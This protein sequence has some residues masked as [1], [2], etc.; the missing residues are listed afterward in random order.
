M[1]YNSDTAGEQ[2]NSKSLQ[3]CILKCEDNSGNTKSIITEGTE[4]PPQA[5]RS[6][7]ILESPFMLPCVSV[8]NIYS[9][10]SWSYFYILLTFIQY[11]FPELA[12]HIHKMCSAICNWW[13]LSCDRIA[14]PFDTV[15][16]ID[17]CWTSRQFRWLAEKW[18]NW[19]IW[20]HLIDDCRHTLHLFYF[21]LKP[22]TQFRRKISLIYINLCNLNKEIS[23]LLALN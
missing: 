13:L 9:I 8:L 20:K 5:I 21:A 11:E 23:W 19:D 1:W 10:D 22:T 16:H 4:Q 12:K 6:G 17:L 7:L 3:G 15:H 18:W 2:R 14:A